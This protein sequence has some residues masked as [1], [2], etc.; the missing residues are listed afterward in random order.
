MITL[1]IIGVVL[2]LFLCSK[3]PRLHRS[4]RS[5]TSIPR[6]AENYASV[7]VIIPAY[8]AAH[9]LPA[10]LADLHNQSLEPVDIVCID[11]QSTDDT[12]LV[13]S[14]LGAKVLSFDPSVSDPSRGKRMQAF[15]QCVRWGSGDYFLFFKPNLR[16]APEAVASMVSAYR[17][18][19]MPLS[20]RP[21]HMLRR[22]YEHISLFVYFF[23]AF[24]KGIG[25]PGDHRH[26]EFSFY[27]DALVFSRYHW[28]LFTAEDSRPTVMP[29]P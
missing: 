26:K 1:A 2:L 29:F 13:A 23:G 11:M 9:E 22:N 15:Q 20:L 6:N 19:G 21:Y 8:N 18:N 16:L 17:K 3:A 14:R 4:G 24:I 12:A 7:S 25:L 28:E 5:A 10:L 27:E